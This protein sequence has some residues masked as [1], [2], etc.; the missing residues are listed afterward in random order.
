M[1]YIFIGQDSISK[2]I[3]LKTLRQE[4]LPQELE[5]FNLDILYAKELNLKT[6]QE[7]LLFFPFKA[8]KRIIII[9]DAQDLKEEAKEFILNFVKKPQAFILLVLDINKYN[10]KDEFIKR[11]TRYSKTL[12]FREPP[13]LDAFT[14]SR[15]L[16]LKKLHY[17][18]QVLNQLLQKGEKPERIMGGL[19]YAW[20]KNST[21]PNELKRRLKALL[22]CDIEIKTG[23]LK[24][25]LALEKFVVGLCC[26]DKPFS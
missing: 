8:K 21:N 1:T 26:F 12:H 5:Q 3:K 7:K 15:A 6:L 14:L 18:L 20:E 10:P 4:F 16:E 25:A 11:I 19:R 22:N 23:R 13:H 9:K 24:P 17:S 2:D